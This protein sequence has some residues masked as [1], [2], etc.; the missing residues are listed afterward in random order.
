MRIE[1]RLNFGSVVGMKVGYAPI[2]KPLIPVIFYYV[3]NLLIDTGAYN[4][5]PSLQRFVQDNRIDQ[6]ALTHYHEDHAG[7]AGFLEKMLNVPVY[8]HLATVSA[9]RNNVALKP[10]EY[11]MFGRLEKAKI[12]PLP[13]VIE[14]ERY[15]LYP[16]HT[17]GHSK[18]HV[19]YHERNEGW[20]FSGD[21]FLSS[22]IKF[23]RKDEN[24]R[25]TIR[26]L[27]KIIALDFDSL[28]CGHNPKMSQPKTYLNAKLEQL[29]QLMDEVQRLINEGLTDKEILRRLS[30]GKEVFLAGLITLGDVSYKH[31]IAS[32]VADLRGS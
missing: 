10:Y 13:K 23:F 30:K 25:Q 21:L 20:V 26:S 1:E 7:N 11:Y 16:I 4:T 14:T 31:I 2:G 6:I 28:F 29:L 12:T 19:I 15:K 9:L 22:R 32:A 18:D 3:D 27:Q 8:G 5:R 17:P 24:I